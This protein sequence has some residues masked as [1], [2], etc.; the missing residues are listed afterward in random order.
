MRAVV[1]RLIVLE[2]SCILVVACASPVS[3]V[4]VDPK[5]VYHQLDRSAVATGDPSWPTRNVLRERGLLEKFDAQPEAA[6]AD[7]HRMMVAAD[8][9]LDALFALAELSEVVPAAGTFDLPFGRLDVSFDSAALRAGD[10][11]MYGFVPTSGLEVE[12]LGMRYRR[13]GIGAPLA[14]PISVA[15]RTSFSI[16]SSEK[17]WTRLGSSSLGSDVSVM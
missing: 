11:E 6:L 15:R 5:T 8:G 1:G 10:R 2:V 9:D 4:R 14:T 3:A 16:S 12:G 17:V 13:A 7:L